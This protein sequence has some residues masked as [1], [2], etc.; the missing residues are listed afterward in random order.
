MNATPPLL[1]RSRL[2]PAVVALASLLLAGVLGVSMP[3]CAMSGPKPLR[4]G[5]NPWPGYEFVYLAQEQG[6]FA[7]R[8]VEVR[9][10]E[11][12]SLSDTR[13]AFEWGQ[14]DVMGTTVV[15]VLQAADQSTRTPQIVRVVDY[16]SGADVILAKPGIDSVRELAGKRVGVELGSVAVYV[17]ARA[18]ATAGLTLQDVTLLPMD[19]FTMEDRFRQ[20]DVQAIVTY[21]P[22]SVALL[23]DG[24][25]HVVFTTAGMPGDVLDVLSVDA[26]LAQARPEQIHRFLAAFDDATAFAGTAPAEATRVMAAREGLAADEFRDVV[27]QGITLVRVSDQDVY[28]GPGGRLTAVIDDTSR[29]LRAIGHLSGPDR[30]AA[31]VNASFAGGTAAP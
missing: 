12:T 20:H 27:A 25:G 19:S 22:S 3:G 11:F 29:V 23:R 26:A 2:R 18:L 21:P 7:A 10:V 4:V 1:G 5:I 9:L 16:S 13:R 28:F 14:I 30:R 31:V 24:V 6:F 17:L 15:E 8:G